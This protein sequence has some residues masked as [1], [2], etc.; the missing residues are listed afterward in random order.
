MDTR[1][2]RIVLKV[3]V[4]CIPR[5]FL[6]VDLP[7]R[8][9]DENSNSLELWPVFSRDG[10]QLAFV[11]WNDENLGE[12]IVADSDGSNPRTITSEPGHYARPEFS[13]DGRLLVFEKE[14]EVI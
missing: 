2:Q 10:Q 9:T 1:S 8:L 12:I 3:W 7:R 6:G 11:R 4:S 14:V 13:P 5:T